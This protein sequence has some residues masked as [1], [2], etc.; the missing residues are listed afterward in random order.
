M[1]TTQIDA[2]LP[3]DAIL[4]DNIKHYLNLTAP[5]AKCGMKIFPLV[6]T[7]AQSNLFFQNYMSILV[8]EIQNKYTTQ[9]TNI[10]KIWAA[11]NINIKTAVTEVIK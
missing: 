7:P 4:A 9:K 6:L 5:D 2:I 1:T 3:V 8:T 11:L 10:A